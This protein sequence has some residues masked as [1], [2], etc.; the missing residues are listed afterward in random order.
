VAA[1]GTL[2]CEAAPGRLND[3]AVANRGEMSPTLRKLFGVR[4]AG[5]TL[6]REPGNGN[7][8][9]FTERTWG[10]F[11]EATVLQGAGPLAGL[12]AQAHFYLQTLAIEGEG[13]T[14]VWMVGD[15][16]AGVMRRVGM[17]QVWLI[18]T[19]LGHGGTAYRAGVKAQ[20]LA[21]LQVVESLLA[22]G[23]VKSTHE[24]RLL[25]RVRG[26]PGKRA[27]FLTN[28]TGE[29]VTESVS[30]GPGAVEDL[31]G[32]PFTQDSNQVTLTVPPLD[33]RVLIGQEEIG[34]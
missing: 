8:W 5:L 14:P 33:V 19:Y 32:E 27:F 29:A 15:E 10:E 30:V 4:Q 23:G 28:P 21:P 20:G 9:S 34:A 17:G 13:V 1:G 11:R 18:G 22:Q 24:G 12:Q 7:R 2:I 31:L 3:H 16:L 6:V 25:L 26:I